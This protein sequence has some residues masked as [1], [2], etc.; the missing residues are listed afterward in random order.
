MPR[1]DLDFAAQA[2]T[3][4]EIAIA[5][6]KCYAHGGAIGNEWTPKRLE[7]LYEFVYLRVFAAWEALLESIFLRSLC[8][9]A[10]SAG[11]ETLVAGGYYATIADA[12]QAVF[13]A[14]SHGAVLKTYVLWHSPQQVIKRCQ[15]HISSGPGL[16]SLQKNVV[17]S[18][19][20]RLESFAAVR[21]R[22]VHDQNDAKLKFNAATLHL[23]GLTYPASRPGKFLRD[24]EVGTAP[25][26]KWLDTAISELTGLA[27]QMV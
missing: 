12:E 18:S 9:Y 10:S 20:A 1:F 24:T 21:H 16:P 17:S 13:A 8:G 6:E 27:G 14:E 7:F 5:G 19:Q 15:A 26:R 11:Q 3:A 22:I 2:Q 25:P 4:S 23:A